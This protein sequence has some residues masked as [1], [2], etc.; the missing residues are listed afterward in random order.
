MPSSRPSLVKACG[1]AL[2][3]LGVAGPVLLG[4]VR[5]QAIELR[6]ST[7]FLRAPWKVDLI[8]YT[9]TVGQTWAEYFFTLELPADAGASLGELLIRQTRGVDTDFPFSADQTRAFVGRPRR[10]GAAIPVTAQF[11]Q[12]ERL[13][14]VQFPQPV[15]PGTTLTVRLRPWTNPGAADTYMFQ[16][17]ALPA[18]PNPLAAPVGFGT[19]RIYQQEWR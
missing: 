5:A 9:T 12:R 16:V 18:G 1:A 2:L 4:P 6:G 19:L 14:R 13:M 17:T 8:S 11:S 15:P 7:M 3:G 10:Q